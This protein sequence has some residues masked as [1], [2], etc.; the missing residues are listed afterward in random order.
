MTKGVIVMLSGYARAGKSTVARMLHEQ[1]DFV[2]MET[3]DVLKRQLW[4][5]NPLVED[6]WRSVRVRSLVPDMD[7][8]KQWEDA[9][10]GRCGNDIR[11]LLQRLGDEA[12]P[13]I[14]GETFLA[15]FMAKRALESAEAGNDVVLGSTRFPVEPQSIH[16]AVVVRINRPGV[17]PAN[18]HPGETAMDDYLFDYIIENDG[19]LND[20][21]I[22][23]KMVVEDIFA[24]SILTS[25]MYGYGAGNALGASLG[26][27]SSWT[28]M[29]E[30]CVH[31]RLGL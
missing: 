4:M 7:S 10:S 31:D 2:W 9:K 1:Y 21:K 17:G 13:Q 20:L 28:T 11:R 6:T 18:D 3:S 16:G 12:G 22:K 15:D 23:V 5:L 19:D 14:F 30:Q 26:L 8:R 27:E 25:R 24:I 29:A